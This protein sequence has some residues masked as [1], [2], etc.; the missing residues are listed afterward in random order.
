MKK[1]I[2]PI[3]LALIMALTLLPTLA[4]ADGTVYIGSDEDLVDAIKDQ[5]VGQTWV[6]TEAGTY[7][8]INTD[9]GS[10]GLYATSAI[11]G[12]SNFVFPIY[13]DNLTITKEDGIG[14]V[15]I[16]SSARPDAQNGGVWDKQNFI[17]VAGSNVTIK[18]VSIKGNPNDYY[19]GLCN[20]AIE[21]CGE[22][23]DFHLKNVELLP[24]EYGDGTITSGSIYINTENPG[25]TVI[26]DVVMYS[27]FTAR[28]VNAGSLTIKN[29]TQDFSNNVYAGYHADGYGYAWNPGVTGS[30]EGI[31]TE[32]FKIIV[33]NKSEL[34]EQIFNSDLR[35]G[36]TVVFT[37][38]DY[39]I[40][41]L[42]I[43]KAV[44]LVGQDD[45][46]LKGSIDYITNANNAEINI[47]G[48]FFEADDTNTNHALNF[49]AL[50]NSKI[51]VDDCLFKGYQFGIGVNSQATGNMLNVSNSEFYEVNC[52][53]GVKVGDAGNDV[54]F[55]GVET[56]GGFAV[57]AFGS[58]SGESGYSVN[59]YY[60]D[61][62]S[63]NEDKEQGF[64]NP[65]FNALETSATLV[66][67]ATF[68]STLENAEAGDTLI[69]AP[70]EYETPENLWFTTPVNIIGSGSDNTIIEGALWLGGG[71]GVPVKDVNT[72]TVKGVTFKNTEG[73]NNW[74][75]AGLGFTEIYGCNITVENCVFDGWQ[76]G[77]HMN[78]EN[79]DTVLNFENVYF[80][81]TF[82]SISALLDGAKIGQIAENVTTDEY[83]AFAVQAFTDAEHDYNYY[84]F[85]DFNTARGGSTE[86]GINDLDNSKLAEGIDYEN[87]GGMLRG[88]VLTDDDNVQAA[89]DKLPDSG[90]SYIVLTPGNYDGFTVDK[91]LTSLG[92]NAGKNPNDVEGRSP[93]SKITGKVT[94]NG[95]TDGTKP[96]VVFDG[97][98][99]TGEGRIWSQNGY[100][101]CGINLTVQ[102]CM[103]VNISD[104]FV[105]TTN[106]GT[107][108]YRNGTI[109]IINNYV[110][111]VHN[112]A[113]TASAFNLWYA[114][115]HIIM[116]NVVEDV[117]YNAFNLNDTVGDVT[118]MDNKISSV[119][120]NGFQIANSAAEGADV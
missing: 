31:T 101:F 89:I 19:D 16:T 57:Q 52:A 40:G 25:N 58:A 17:T 104:H 94:I 85:A 45:V 59:A 116:G 63:Y 35:D 98:A 111:G 109:K 78:G 64:I 1:R 86:T 72:L 53:A 118:F 112:T 100:G 30:Y 83:N 107:G 99:F 24:L 41:A 21:L 18:N 11:A 113:K 97:V 36:T 87:G 34:Q 79:T 110:S 95:Y 74:S 7:D 32:N 62:I 15:V 55:E 4:L 6:F 84:T 82:V 39:D 102:N 43:N 81:N 114:E 9:E 70:G 77:V 3:L 60:K 51:N 120:Q 105:Y 106:P 103:A 33:D 48:L 28:K 73:V 92:A 67:P 10:N 61:Y 20:K 115:E 80:K 66:I 5:A 22:A 37:K 38:G 27:W 119:G 117:D 49:S 46:T 2:L 42:R 14:E 54:T 23:Q 88:Y 26:E 44:N 29:L 90:K 75:N 96:T 69:L 93:L 68:E 12:G 65:D 76:Y 8:A 50:K 13:V 91:S 108:D 71:N 47:S 56:N